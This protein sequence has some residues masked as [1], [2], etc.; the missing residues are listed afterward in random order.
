V[1][2]A[3]KRLIQQRIASCDI[4]AVDVGLWK[5][6]TG[7]EVLVLATK[8]NTSV[9]LKFAKFDFN[10]TNIEWVTVANPLW[11]VDY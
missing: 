8:T 3:V 9:S 6:N 11:P 5:I 10:E 4:Q 2:S 1:H 7:T